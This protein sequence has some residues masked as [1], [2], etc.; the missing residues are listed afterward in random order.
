[1][2]SQEASEEQ[3]FRDQVEVNL[4][5]VWN[6]IQAA[7]PVMIEQGR[8]GA[9][10]LTGSTL[11]LVRRGRNGRGGSDRVFASKHALGGLG[12]TS[13][14]CHDPPNISAKRSLPAASDT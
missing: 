4:F 8:G 11:G 1:M 3:A 13:A 9:I 7:A 6:T 2:M 5:G 12:R 14:P 10:V